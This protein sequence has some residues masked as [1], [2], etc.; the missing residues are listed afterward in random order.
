MIKKDQLLALLILVLGLGLFFY[1]LLLGNTF[2]TVAGHQSS[3]YPWCVYPTGISDFPQSDQA[4]LN[5]PWQSYLSRSIHQAE[6]PLWNP[7][8]FAGQPIFSN[9][10][11]AM[12]YPPR[13]LAALFF[14]PSLAHD[15][16]SVFHLLLGGLSMYLLL[17]DFGAGF[18]GAIYA[19][20]A[21]MLNTFSLAWLHLEVVAPVFTFLPLT[22]FCIH[23]AA[24]LHSWRWTVISCVTLGVLLTAGHLPFMGVTFLTAASYAMWLGLREYLRRIKSG[25]SFIASSIELLR[26][27][28]SVFLAGGLAAV[29]LVPTLMTIA[30]S[31]RQVFRYEDVHESIR[32]SF[33][34]LR[35]LLQ[36]VTLPIS[37]GA[38][39]R[40]A[41]TGT[42]TIILALI[43]AILPGSGPWFA[44]ILALT[45]VLIMTDFLMLK[46]LYWI[47]P[48]FSV[49]RPLGRLLFILNFAVIILG[50]FGLDAI[51]RWIRHPT[52]PKSLQKII[53]IERRPPIGLQKWL[54]R[55]ASVGVCLI[56]LFTSLQ[57]IRYGRAIN[58]P[59]HERIA[60]NLYPTTPMIR[61]LIDE[62]K[63]KS[64]PGRVIPVS[65]TIDNGWIPPV[66]FGA[67]SLVFGIESITGYDSV[68]P[69]WSL[70]MIRALGGEDIE[71]LITRPYMSSAAPLMSVQNTRFD[72]IK[73]IGITLVA[74]NPDITAD[75]QW[76][77][78]AS[79]Y[80][81]QI[82]AGPDGT[83][84]R[85]KESNAGPRVVYK[86]ITVP[87]EADALKQLFD[88]SFDHRTSVIFHNSEGKIPSA[89][90]S[91]TWTIDSESKKNNQY[92]IKLYTS[93]PGWLVIPDTYDSGWT[94]SVNEA[95]TPILR[96]NYAFRAIQVPKGSVHVEMRY[97]PKG[98]LLGIFITL[99]VVV[100]LVG[101]FFLNYR[102][103]LLH[104]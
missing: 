24:I 21:W 46:L 96:A 19:A 65:R 9:G 59:F 89:S 5:Y 72:V 68:I 48:G 8:S 42:I 86:V 51:W 54:I 79:Q 64:S 60:S 91:G 82:Y 10:S 103:K 52:I 83:V 53:T 58:P 67:E 35:Y 69:R 41:F 99:S 23:R 17:R 32:L 75:P 45:I 70:T 22:I 81:E 104:K 36:P 61:V 74:S 15:L 93:E 25:D 39:H 44:R 102:P 80:L 63:P 76:K 88:K 90:L 4:D 14:S 6:L 95:P 18:V 47:V 1:P 71:Q 43:G 38:M 20:L 97:F 12:F 56:C 85:V 50:G 92:N 73:K 62:T 2:S 29:V 30:D 3:V 37:E 84:F 31:Q 101:L 100:V 28:I 33:S 49:F 40:M 57:L 27:C 78:R 26:P 7:Y 34:D 55:G 77:I 94:A 87:S 11:S 16:L 13:F 66:L 98:L